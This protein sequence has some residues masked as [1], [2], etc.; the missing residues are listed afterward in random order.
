M[1][2]GFRWQF[3]ALILAAALFVISL[4]TQPRPPEPTPTPTG[5][6][7]MT[8]T[9]ILEAIT[10]PPTSDVQLTALPAGALAAYREGLIGT[11]QRLNPLFADMNPTDRDITS[12]IFEGLVRTNAFG[13]PIPGLAE[14]WIVSSDGLEYVFVLRNDILWQDG[15]PFSAVD[16]A[17]TMSLLRSPTFPGSAAAR[18]FWRTIETEVIGENRIRFRLTQ[19]LG[20][21]LDK[22]QIGILPEHALRGTTAAQLAAHPFNF[23]PI[24]T[25]PY[26]LENIEANSDNQITQIDLRLSANYLQR[27]QTQQPQIERVS[28]RFFG[29]FESAAAALADGSID[30]LAGT[31]GQ[32]RRELFNLSNG[33][34]NVQLY[35][36]IEPTLGVL[37]FNWQRPESRFLRDQR[38]RVALQ[39]G[40]DRSSVIERNLPNIA[41]EASSPLWPSAWAYLPALPW[42]AYDP[43]AAR[44]ELQIV[45][46]RLAA[47][48]ATDEAEPSETTPAPA[49]GLFSLRVLVPE[50]PAIVPLAQEIAAQWSQLGLSVIVEA[51]PLGEYRGQLEAGD[52][53][54]A[55]VEYALG[56]STDPDVYPFWHQGQTPPDGDNY[57]GADDRR[58]SELLERARRDANGM[59]RI[60][61]YREFQRQFVD[62]A[63]A[64]PLYYPLFTYAVSNRVS[65]VQLGAIGSWADRFRNIGEWR[66]AG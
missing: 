47:A 61:L 45:G 64:I 26:Q 11:P 12:L 16:V 9:A 4:L 15:I 50:D 40:L 36:Q 2:R 23:T 59:N 48:P 18:D 24:G 32:Q 44:S 27:P 14:R 20:T 6:P 13:E 53:D 37:I 62:R 42:R 41:V 22:L 38:V 54:A 51:E 25:G 34:P 19:P 21:F 7:A 17:Y 1:L 10:P 8:P 60:E 39:T 35:T 52:F 57:G 5:E 3:L 58:I 56:S 31:T 29:T 55:L 30:G 63:I 66:L 65:G 43:N 28:F 46:Q 33:S 49:G